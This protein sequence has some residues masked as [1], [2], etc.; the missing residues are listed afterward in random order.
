M[1]LGGLLSVYVFT[2]FMFQGGVKDSQSQEV[3][4]DFICL[5][6]WLGGWEL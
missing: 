2:V 1:C 6:T 5:L 3:A 4:E